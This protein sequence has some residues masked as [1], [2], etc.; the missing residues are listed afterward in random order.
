MAT[1]E[2]DGLARRSTFIFS[3]TVERTAAATLATVPV[4][5]ATAV[6]RVDRVFRAPEILGDQTDRR[7]TVQLLKMDVKE[8]TRALFFANGWLY[9]DGIAVTEV[10]RTSLDD[11]D[12]LGKQVKR[13]EL[14]AEER[15]LLERI[16]KASLVV[17]GRVGRIVPQRKREGSGDSEHE[18]HWF[19]ADLEVES[20]EKGRHA[21]A[22]PAPLAFPASDDVQWYWRPKPQPG[23]DGIW[24]LHR[25]PF[26]GLPKAA[27]TALDPRDFQPRDQLEHVRRLIARAG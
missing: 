19:V 2:I 26:P 23:Q 27:F 18:P 25:E 1:R 20:V 13:A 15:E 22:K 21:R 3:G 16:A 24:I 8:G 12:E 14:R 9:G 10:G 17:V 7:I 4:D 5:D 6:V 11:S